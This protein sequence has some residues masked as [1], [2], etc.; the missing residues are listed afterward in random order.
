[1]AAKKLSIRA[2][3]KHRNVSP[4]AVATAIDSGRITPDKNGKIDPEKADKE[5][6]ENTRPRKKKNLSDSEALR[7]ASIAHEAAR[8][9][10]TELRYRKL[11]GEL[12]DRDKVYAAIFRM[13]RQERDAWLNWPA[14]VSH[15]MAADLNVDAAT[16]HTVLERY[17]NEHLSELSD[18]RFYTAER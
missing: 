1:M 14:R 6:L 2:Y 15:R 10:L 5:W 8:A 11:K 16:L 7:N 3:A 9:R 13:G 17:I 18:F 12:V 4:N